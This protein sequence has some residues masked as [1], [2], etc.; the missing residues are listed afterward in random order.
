MPYDK[1][2]SLR[3]SDR[4]ANTLLHCRLC[5]ISSCFAR[6]S[7]W[8][9]VDLKRRYRNIQN[10]WMN[11][12]ALCL[13]PSAICISGRSVAA[14]PNSNGSAGKCLLRSSDLSGTSSS[15]ARSSWHFDASFCRRLQPSLSYWGFVE[16]IRIY[17]YLN[18]R[19]VYLRSQLQL[20]WAIQYNTIEHLY[21][22][23]TK[24]SLARER[25]MLHS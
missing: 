15:V 11:E 19:Y 21:R 25:V 1:Y 20:L 16:C 14:D 12:L 10:Y 18:W 5:L 8:V 17:L 22:A 6:G 24:A 9:I 2:S 7:A 13:G 4:N 23:L 3:A